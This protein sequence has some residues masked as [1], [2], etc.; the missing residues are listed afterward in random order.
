MS[1]TCVIVNPNAGSVE[2]LESLR[3]ALSALGEVDVRATEHAGHAE[4]LALEA[5]R[6]GFA[7]VAAAGGDGTLNEVV[8]GLAEAP[9]KPR[10]G[11]L[12]LGTGNDFARTLELPPTSEE[13]VRVLAEGRARSCD[14][15]VLES[16]ETRRYF[17]NLSTGGFSGQVDEQLTDEIKSAWGPLAYLRAALVCLPEIDPYTL[18]LTFDGEQNLSLDAYNLVVA[19]GRYVAA[20]MPAAPEARIDD[21]LLDVVAIRACDLTALAALAPRALAGEY[22]DDEERIFFRRARRLEIRSHP[23][24]TFNVDGEVV[25]DSDVSFEVVPDALDVIVPHLE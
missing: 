24:M 12:P 8:N 16:D 6:E 1:S 5:A 9:R 21:G 2:D 7:T 17:I 22:L 11:L 14:L 13:A 15:A 19:N 20:G 23:R 18:E 4:E 25:G 3:D 10:L